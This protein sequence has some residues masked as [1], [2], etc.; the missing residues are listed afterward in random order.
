MTVWKHMYVVSTAFRLFIIMRTYFAIP[1]HQRTCRLIVFCVVFQRSRTVLN[2]IPV[3]KCSLLF[4][5]TLDH[6]E[7]KLIVLMDREN[8]HTA[9]KNKQSKYGKLY[10]IKHSSEYLSI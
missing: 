3:T 8:N 1:P 10:F 7:P 4:S 6:R 5:C 2:M 9:N